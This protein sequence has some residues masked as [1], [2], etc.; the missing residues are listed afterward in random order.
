MEVVVTNPTILSKTISPWI[1]KI[2]K[3]HY[4]ADENVKYFG[5]NMF[6]NVSDFL[7]T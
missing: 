5:H 2:L 4:I 7:V 1:L 3:M 6:C